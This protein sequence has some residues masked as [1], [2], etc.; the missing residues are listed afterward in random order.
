MFIG[1]NAAGKKPFITPKKPS[2]L[3]A[4]A[5]RKMIWP[6]FFPCSIHPYWPYMALYFPSTESDNDLIWPFFLWGSSRSEGKMVLV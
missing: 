4:L 6:S 3:L 5:L 2:R 1:F